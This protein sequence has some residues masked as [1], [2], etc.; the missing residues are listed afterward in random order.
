M[1]RDATPTTTLL[2]DPPVAETGLSLATR[3]SLAVAWRAT[4][5][6]RLLIWV[7]G[8]AAFLVWGLMGR[9]TDFDPGGI[10]S[11]FG[12]V[13]NVLMAPAARGD[14]T[15]F[16]AIAQSGYGTD[17]ARPAFFPL[18]PLA[19]RAGG[20]FTGDVVIAGLVVS[21]AA[22]VVALAALHR[23]T[24]LELG[25]PAARLTVWAMAL[26][27]MSFFLSAVYSESLFLM[28]AV[29]ALLAARLDRW[30]LAGLLGG[31]AAATR[32]AGLVVALA[33]LLL[34]LDARRGRVPEAGGR[35]A[36]AWP[37][38][39]WIA[40]V[41]LGPAL[42]SL[43]FA[44]RGLDAM[45]PFHAQDEW[46][47][48]FAG[49]FVGVWD[50]TVAAFDGARQLLS[51]SR[52]PVYFAIAGGDPYNVAWHNL[53]PFAFLVLTVPAVIGVWRRMAP[54]YTAYVLVS[55]AL[56]LSYPVAPQPLMSYPRFVA[57]VF[58]LFMWAGAWAAAGAPW[59][60]R[61]LLGV[62][63]AGLVACTAQF[64]TWHWIA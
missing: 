14:T 6:S 36:P 50:G 19:M 33:L 4:W 29:G 35:P 62:S 34:F 59:R 15:W 10:T 13:G 30:A 57:V 12:S 1:A 39:L 24:E 38:V 40:L 54:A 16:S 37:R 56:P 3:R 27:P 9:S 64:A 31:L 26:F 7:T 45:A 55:L 51:G 48:S 21:L 41:P 20:V 2:S 5:V 63:A 18:Y 52:T 44:V 11:H 53:L 61:V 58:P 49:P 8:M 17:V 42:F 47:R 23:L 22:M 43:W 28:L 32:S 46:M 60:A 25:G